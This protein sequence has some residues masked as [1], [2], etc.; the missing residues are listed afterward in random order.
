[1]NYFLE[2]G[3]FLVAGIWT[4]RRWLSDR[5][6]MDRY[7]LCTFALAGTSFL[8]CTFFRSAVIPNNDL[9]WRGFLLGQFVLLLW[10]VDLLDQIP[11]ARRGFLT[12]LIVIG[13]ASSIYEAAALRLYPIAFD[14][15]DIPRQAWLSPDHNLGRRTYALRTGYEVLEGKLPARAVV[16]HNPTVVPDDLPYGLYADRP[17][18]DE[19]PGC[20]G[21][22]GGD[23]A[24]CAFVASALSPIFAG[25][26]PAA[27]VD[28]TCTD[29]SISAVL[30]KD[31]DPAW[32]DRTSWIWHR[33]PIVAN[34]FMRALPCGSGAER[35]LSRY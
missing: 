34:R 19:A 3:A 17:V 2:F 25:S 21:A 27:E 35:L 14:V 6:G 13:V 23:P 7:R 24:S 4:V 33:Q 16:Q 30:V 12:V 1:L 11:A 9:G 15:L 8:I 5:K 18:V 28:R 22:F 31:I 32:R 26:L 29:L 10:T 20:G